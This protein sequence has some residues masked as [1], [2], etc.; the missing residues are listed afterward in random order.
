MK[1]FSLILIGGIIC[2]LLV[3]WAG[4]SGASTALVDV[5][6]E[7]SFK[8]TVNKM[9][10]ISA[11]KDP[12]RRRIWEDA[13]CRGLVKHNVAAMAS[14]NLFPDAFPDTLQIVE[15]V[16][17]NGF[18]GVMITHRL[19]TETNP[20]YVE[21]YVSREKVERYNRHWDKFLIYYRDVEHPGYIDSQKVYYRAFDIWSTVNDGQLI[22]SATSRTPDP[23]QGQRA[24][25]PE[26]IE[27]VLAKLSHRGIIGSQRK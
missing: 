10:V 15:A 27:M 9:L 13:L 20:Q 12:V 17:S 18:D 19:P 8:T 24:V 4:C 1:K 21:G 14:Y 3:L 16:Q 22:W 5:W 25:R 11:A 7:A 23:D 26:I 2:C 6:S